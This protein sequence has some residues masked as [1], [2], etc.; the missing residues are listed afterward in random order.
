MDDLTNLLTE[1]LE[2][3]TRNGKT[4]ADVLWCGSTD[5]HF[6]WDDFSAVANT[7]NYNDGY[8][9][10]E[11]APD[12]VVVGVDWWLERHEYYGSESWDFKTLPVKPV[13][14]TYPKRLVGG[15]KTSLLDSQAEEQEY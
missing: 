2:V 1:T 3:L 13:Q 7:T 9:A 14:Y 5:L 6:S 11:I 10:V 12:L 4:P 8:G 15:W